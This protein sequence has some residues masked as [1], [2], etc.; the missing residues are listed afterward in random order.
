M[1][2]YRAFRTARLQ[3][4][5]TKQPA[6]IGQKPELWD[7]CPKALWPDVADP[8]AKIHDHWHKMMVRVIAAVYR[9][10]LRILY[11]LSL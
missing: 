6:D 3:P 4:V 5:I 11:L 8:S 7:I 10:A 9:V 2:F 1:A